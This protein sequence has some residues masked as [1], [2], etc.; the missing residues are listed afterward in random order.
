[1][2]T[3][4]NPG[5]TSYRVGVAAEAIAAAVLAQCGY[6]ISVQYGANQ[7]VYDLVAVKPNRVLQISV[8]GSKAGGWGLTQNYKRGRTYQAAA[9]E[10]LERHGPDLVFVFVEYW[11]VTVG[12]MPRI[13]VARAAEV[14]THLSNACR[15]RGDTTL[16]ENH[17]WRRGVLKGYVETI[18]ETWKLTQARIDSV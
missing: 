17:A 10:W 18:P 15:G 12:S 2:I 13:Y 5:F 16:M 6:D 14:A 8:K 4:D 3:N 9:A 1:M 11:G 7:P